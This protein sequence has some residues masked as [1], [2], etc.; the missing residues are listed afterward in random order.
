MARTPGVFMPIPAKVPSAVDAQFAPALL[1]WHGHHGR[2]DL[3]WQKDRTLYRVWV[4]EIM[5]QQTQVATVIPYY[6]RFMERFP[7]VTDLAGAPLDEVLHYWSGLGYYA[8]AR[9]LHLAARRIAADHDGRVPREFDAL[10]AL[11]G[12]GRSTAGAILS[13][14]LDQRQPILDG[15]VRRVLA[16]WAGI[17]GFPGAQQ[18]EKRLWAASEAV[19]PAAD[20]AAFT[21]AIMDLGATLCTRS[22]PR[23]GD[24]PVAGDCVALAT[25]RT[26]VLPHARPG[27]AR[28]A[29]DVV[30]LVLRRGGALLLEQRP[31]TGLWGGLWG[32][33]EFTTAVA[34]TAAARAR[35]AAPKARARRHEPIS[36]EF[37]HFTLRITPLLHELPDDQAAGAVME[38]GGETWYNS[39]RPAKLGLAAPV[40]ALVGRLAAP[41]LARRGR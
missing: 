30:W 24:C 12:I 4:S 17:E 10:H 26:D 39:R 3:P 38:G 2:H 35:G 32:F 6:A 23:C 9:N 33:P 5:L 41:D 36:H 16:R 13:L 1:A 29:R 31:P 22:Q 25:D 8:R 28:P 27:K 21:Q 20:S 37:T 19:T 34:A 7:G 15:N 14:A 40:T 18:V 11:P